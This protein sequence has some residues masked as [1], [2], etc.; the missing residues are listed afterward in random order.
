MKKES[1][2]IFRHSYDFTAEV[3]D[4]NIPVMKKQE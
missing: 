1:C 2:G 3:P 4:L